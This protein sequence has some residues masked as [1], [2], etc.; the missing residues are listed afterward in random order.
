MKLLPT[1]K[2]IVFILLLNLGCSTPQQSSETTQKQVALFEKGAQK[3]SDRS[4]RELT[5]ALDA[6][7]CFSVPDT[8][9][10][11]DLNLACGSQDYMLMWDEDAEGHYVPGT[12]VECCLTPD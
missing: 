7:D 10:Q 9:T 12:A 11:A 6:D 2:A 3:D 8:A 1:T 5:T 4:L